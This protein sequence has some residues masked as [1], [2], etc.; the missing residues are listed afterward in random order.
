[1]LID[2]KRA[3]G[4]IALITTGVAG[5]V[6]AYHDYRHPKVV[7]VTEIT[8]EYDHSADLPIQ[9]EEALDEPHFVPE[10]VVEVAVPK[11]QPKPEE[12][13][14]YI[15]PAVVD[16]MFGSVVAP[17]PVFREPAPDFIPQEPPVA[18]QL[19][20]PTDMKVIQT[21]NDLL[22]GRAKTKNWD[23]LFPTVIRQNVTWRKAAFE[24]PNGLTISM[25]LFSKTGTPLVCGR[26]NLI[27]DTRSQMDE[28]VT[29]RQQSIISSVATSEMFPA[30]A[31]PIGV[32]TTTTL[33]T[34]IRKNRAYF[35]IPV[36]LVLTDGNL[37]L[38]ASLMIT[39]TTGR[40]I[41]S[42][43]RL[44]P[45]AMDATAALFTT[46]RASGLLTMPGAIIDV[47]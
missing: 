37:K 8:E 11:P 28:T 26:G 21:T 41:P 27:L 19:L 15:D 1:M 14:M 9:E 13:G 6:A 34:Y 20:S 40:P 46:A 7:D 32:G 12:P 10:P 4:G 16:A 30:N 44:I 39:T 31:T 35:G 17:K 22:Y 45:V 23:M 3:F 47:A 43:E 5:L 36:R 24:V 33:K 29:R 18:G 38:D 2:I 25:V 42:I